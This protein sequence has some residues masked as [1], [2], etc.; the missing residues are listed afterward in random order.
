MGKDLLKIFHEVHVDAILGL[1]IHRI[2]RFGDMHRLSHADF[3]ATLNEAR[4]EMEL[5][6]EMSLGFCFQEHEDGSGI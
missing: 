2:V 5:S 1:G 4:G 6:L 3:V